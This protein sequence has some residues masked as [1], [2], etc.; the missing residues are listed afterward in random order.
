MGEGPGDAHALAFTT[1]QFDWTAFRHGRVGLC[2]AIVD[3][4]TFNATII[5]TGIDS[6]RFAQTRAR[7]AAG[8]S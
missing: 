3:R 1:R 8:H 2:V 4:L 6:Y 5:E 7:Q